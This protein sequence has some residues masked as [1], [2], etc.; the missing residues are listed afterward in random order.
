MPSSLFGTLVHP[1]GLLFSTV[2]DQLLFS[3]PVK[4]DGMGI[5]NPAEMANIAYNT[6]V[7]GTRHISDAIK[8]RKPFSLDG[9]GNIYYAPWTSAARSN[10]IKFSALHPRY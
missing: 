8:E 7:S 9:R 10:H 2:Q 1:F 6:S 3:I 4:M 5:H